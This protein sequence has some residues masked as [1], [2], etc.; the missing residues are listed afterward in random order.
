MS[1]FYDDI[2]SGENRRNAT[3][4]PDF[5]AEYAKQL[6]RNQQQSNINKV[7]SDPVQSQTLAAAIL[8]IPYTAPTEENVG[9]LRIKAAK[10]QAFM[11]GTGQAQALENKANELQKYIDKENER[12]NQADKEYMAQP[13]LLTDSE[14]QAR[15]LQDKM[16]EVKGQKAAL[17]GQLTEIALRQ[18]PLMQFLNGV[19]AINTFAYGNKQVSPFVKEQIQA[20]DAQKQ[21]EF[22]KTPNSSLE[23][24]LPHSNLLT[25]KQQIQNLA[26][27]L[28]IQNDELQQLYDDLQKQYDD[29]VKSDKYIQDNYSRWKQLAQPGY[30][31]TTAEQ[32]EAK[33]AI[34]LLKKAEGRLRGFWAEGT[35]EDKSAAN[36]YMALAAALESKTN[37]VWAFGG[38]VIGSIP[39]VK[40]YTDWLQTAPSTNRFADVVY[41]DPDIKSITLNTD[42]YDNY[43]QSHPVASMAGEIVGNVAWL[44]A[45]GEVLG[46]LGITSHIAKNAILFGTSGAANSAAQQDWSKPGS[47][48]LNTGLDT[49]I[50]I[51]SGYIGGKAAEA[52]MFKVGQILENATISSTT[53]KAC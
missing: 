40:Q 18:S 46:G 3:M 53:A 6:I 22:T 2:I 30:K 9:D 28:H 44:A 37:V 4:K 36:N 17:K 52:T 1:T 15:D 29:L 48:I 26:D 45:G 51:L 31:L 16:N 5:Q 13:A 20:M 21:N 25:E 32:E 33:Q 23:A 14:M 19:S 12:N 50:S 11:P 42:Y 49:G 43:Q 39:G 24:F 38:N 27:D 35:V 8:G 41:T 7:L 10:A 34:D 47:A